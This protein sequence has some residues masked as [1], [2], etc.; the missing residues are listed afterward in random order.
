MKFSTVLSLLAAPLLALADSVPFER[1]NAS[2][3]VLLILD[4]QVGL[5]T[6]ARDFDP[7]LY[8]ENLIAHAALGKLFPELPVIMTTSA[9]TGPNGPLPKE[10]LEMYPDAPLI[11]RQ[12]EVDAWD[13][14]E[15]RAAVEATGRKQII[16]AGVTTDVCTAFLALSLRA[17]GYSVWANVEASGTTSALVR[18]VSNDRMR[19]A[20]VQLVSLFSIVCDLMRD[21]RNTP[22]AKEAIPWL[23]RYFPVYGYLA[24]G[25]GA[26]VEN[27]TLIPGEEELLA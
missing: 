23:D 21:W 10:I 19:D 17:E 27:G 24:R 1:L 12:G 2:D 15:F 6:V 16:V 11:K 5:Y 13:N 3:A 14:A 9:E 7:T 4:L 25:H 22:G 20:G 18:D 8:R 26:A